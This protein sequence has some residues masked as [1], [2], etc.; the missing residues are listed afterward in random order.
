[1]LA[2]GGTCAT[3]LDSDPMLMT[4]QVS[5]R[6]VGALQTGMQAKV[7]LVTGEEIAGTIRYIAPTADEKTPHL[8]GRHRDGQ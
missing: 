2:I 5:E 8:P 6:D 4:G 7:S 1:M 3:I